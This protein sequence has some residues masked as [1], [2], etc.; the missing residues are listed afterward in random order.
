MDKRGFNQVL[1]SNE[2]DN[3]VNLTENTITNFHTNMH[4]LQTAAE[5][6]A[7]VSSGRY[8]D[9]GSDTSDDGQ[10]LV[11]H[12]PGSV[13]PENP[14]TQ[15]PTTVQFDSDPTLGN[16]GEIGFSPAAPDSYRIK[17]VGNDGTMITLVLSS[18]V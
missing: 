14:W 5:D 1:L 15:T 17:A 18:G 9:N 12:V 7:A 13:F 11:Q 16:P 6:F 3:K 4:L 8:P 2:E 10:T